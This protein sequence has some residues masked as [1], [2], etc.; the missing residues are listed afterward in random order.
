MRL[1][2]FAS[3]GTGRYTQ[4]RMPGQPE[5]IPLSAAPFLLGDWLVEPS[6]NR[7][8]RGEETVQLELR[9]M[10]VLLC[11]RAAGGE[12]VSK[13]TLIDTVWQTEFVAE[14]T[15]TRRIADLR[16]VL[17]DDARAP[18]YIETIPRRGY[19]VVAPIADAEDAVR[20]TPFPISDPKEDVGPYPGLAPFAESDAEFFFGREHETTALWRKIANRRLLAVAGP[21]G[22]GK[23]SFVRAGVMATAPDGWTTVVF[24]PGEAPFASLARALAPAFFDDLEAIRQLMG[25]H[26]MDAALA[27]VSRW[28]ERTRQAL[29]VVDQF[30]ELFTLNLGAVQ[31]EFADFLLRAATAADVH[32]ALVLRDDFLHECQNQPALRAVLK[33]LTML[34]PLDDAGLLRAIVKPA[35]K[36]GFRFSDEILAEE[37]LA[38]VAGERG[39]LPMLAFAVRQL[40]ERRDRNRSLLT[41]EVYEEMGGVGGALVRHAEATLEAIGPG[42]RPLVREIFR[43]LVT[44]QGTRA[45][46]DAEELLSVFDPDQRANAQSVLRA[47]IE[48]RLLTTYGSGV[49]DGAEMESCRRVEIVH[50][51]LLSSWPRLVRWQTQDADAAQ[52]RDQLR[53]AARLW[54]D[55]GRPRDLVWSGASHRELAVWLENYPGGLSA[56]EQAFVD[57]ADEQAG[58]RR[59]RRWRMAAGAFLALTAV[60]MSLAWL[61][62]DSVQQARRAEALLL[63]AR[64]QERLSTDTPLAL[65]FATASLE[66]DDDPAVRALALESLWRGP[67]PLSLVID[68]TGK[69]IAADV[70]LSPDRRWLSLGFYDGSIRLWDSSGREVAFRETVDSPPGEPHPTAVRFSPDSAVLATATMPEAVMKFWSVPGLE[71]LSVQPLE[72]PLDIGK[73]LK[74]VTT[75]TWRRLFGLEKS[76]DPAGVEWSA[77]ED[78]I[79]LLQKW[80]GTLDVAADIDHGRKWMIYGASRQLWAL[81]LTAAD[82]TTPQVVGRT[83]RDLAQLVFH[84]KGDRFA[85]LDSGGEIQL[86]AVEGSAAIPL[87]SWSAGSARATW[88]LRFSPSGRFLAAAFNSGPALQVW[89]LEG[90]PDA[91]PISLPEMYAPVFGLVFDRE[92]RWIATSGGLYSSIWPLTRDRRPYLLP[93]HA[94][95]VTAVTFAPDGSWLAS[96]SGDGTIRWWPMSPGVGDGQRVLFDWGHPLE[97]QFL[98]LESDPK[99]RFVVASADRGQI[100]VLFLDGSPPRSLEGFSGPATNLAVGPEGRFVAAGG[101]TQSPPDALVRVWDLESNAVTVLDLGDGHNISGVA[102][103]QEGDLLIS[104]GGKLRRWNTATLEYSVIGDSGS[105]VLSADRRHVL[106]GSSIWDDDVHTRTFSI[107][108]LVDGTSRQLPGFLIH[109]GGMALDASGSVV[110]MRGTSGPIQVGSSGGGEPH[111]LLGHPSASF[112]MSIAMSPDGRWIAAGS[113]NENV[114]RLWPVP[115]VSKTPLHVLSHDEFLARL[116][117]QTNHRIVPVDRARSG[118]RQIHDPFPG[119]EDLPE[120][121]W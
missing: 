64:S 26:D 82:E 66:R 35:R 57:A 33:D 106:R 89:D 85:T 69:S 63:R 99:G 115:D 92:E 81:D 21:S 120:L 113:G 96:A 60:A 53:Q 47:L 4:W 30:E 121:P 25:T 93:G 59:R 51:S 52:F 100:K 76:T 94:A 101:G 23:S 78:S 119:W 98:V 5:T 80:A 87:R 32:V 109:S 44:A 14:N 19:R 102:F 11:L 67:M 7:L 41:R 58:R 49:D 8:S 56:A 95:G 71:A 103:T 110:A 40:W 61:W 65:A 55:R 36:F 39:A 42:N 90:P 45:V 1:G 12:V 31:T 37:M 88:D 74:P 34:G 75:S 84:P 27:L 62:R 3:G 97:A 72:R 22:M 9:A 91:A 77:D 6:L 86:W 15:L 118:Y 13:R 68:P 17:G 50:E 29:L 28:R 54:H 20:V 111:L 104:S 73:D 38:E 107:L 10:D 79:K 43:N 114:I 108:D 18:R 105:F 48:A 116:K 24:H 117:T 46:R 2:G 112:V 83:D 16:Q 70:D